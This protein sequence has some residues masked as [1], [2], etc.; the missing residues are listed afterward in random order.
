M[1]LVN[2][3]TCFDLLLS[4]PRLASIYSLT[5]FFCM[6]FLRT[7]NRNENT[8]IEEIIIHIGRRTE[9]QISRFV[10]ALWLTVPL[11]VPCGL[12][13]LLPTQHHSPSLSETL[14]YKEP[15]LKE[16]VDKWHSKWRQTMHFSRLGGT[17]RVI[18]HLNA[19]QL[20]NYRN[21]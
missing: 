13:D 7:K 4:C 17:K 1:L 11:F 16:S 19:L 10:Y 3:A 21:W 18:D 8:K 14:V 15:A 9:Y 2:S 20:H 6:P 12:S 5:D